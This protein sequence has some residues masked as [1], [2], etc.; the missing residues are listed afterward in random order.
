MSM[1]LALASV[2]VHDELRHRPGASPRDSPA[3]DKVLLAAV[4]QRLRELIG[5]G[6]LTAQVG[7]AG[8]PFVFWSEITRL[9]GEGVFDDLLMEL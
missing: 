4:E 1:R 6:R 9:L 8:Q 2:R 3:R 5:D 7:Y